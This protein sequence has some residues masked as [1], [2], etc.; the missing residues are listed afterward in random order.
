MLQILQGF[1]TS[2]FYWDRI[3]QCYRSKDGLYV[4]HLSQ[5]SLRMVLDQF[6]YSATCLKMVEIRIEKMED[7]SPT[8]TAFARSVSAW[9]AVSS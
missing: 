4:T 7:S 5:T 3:G 1:S 6:I 9:L 2:L 8:L